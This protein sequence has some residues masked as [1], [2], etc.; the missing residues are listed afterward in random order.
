MP[1]VANLL[2]RIDLLAG[3]DPWLAPKLRLSKTSALSPAAAN[4]SAYR[5]RYISLTAEYPCAITI[6]GRAPTESSAV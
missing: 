4:T 5:S 3:I 1:V 6:V 2:P